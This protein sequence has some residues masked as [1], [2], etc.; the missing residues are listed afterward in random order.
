MIR[1]GIVGAGSIASKFARDIKHV[2]G[3]VTTAI[4]SRDI[5]KAIAFKNE[6]DI[7]FAFGNYEE[8]AKSD[9]IDA[10]YIATPHNFHMEQSILFMNHKKHVLCEKPISVNSKQFKKM[11][12]SAKENKVLLMEAM[13]TRFLPATLKVREVISSNKLGKFKHAHLEFGFSFIGKG[14]DKGRLFNP[15]LAGGS[16]LD[17]GIYPVAYT[18]NLTNQNIKSIKAKAN[19]YKTGVDSECRIEFL[20]EDGAT[21]SL[22]SS[23]EEDRNKPGVLEFENGTI[24][25][26]HFWSSE[27]IIVNGEVFEYPHIGEGFPYEIDSFV[28]TIE[29]G[30][31]E[32]DIMTYEETRKSMVLLDKIRN[33]IGLV[34]P[35]E[36]E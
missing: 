29:K 27:K 3:A 1:F 13:W 7:E 9:K 17:M 32:N 19:I 28:K 8:M 33:E 34:Y 11:V 26:D 20:F 35:F 5:D 6:Y 30:D 10:V 4:A 24:I 36:K 31:L 2:K 15:N 14:G 18:L 23:F 22:L 12:L 21:A 16:L 25:V